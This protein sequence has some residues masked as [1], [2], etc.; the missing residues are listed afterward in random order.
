M[1]FVHLRT[2]TEYSVVDGTLRIDDAAD[3]AKADGQPALAI[4]D[5]SNLFGA[6][7]FY[8][9]CR[10]AGVKPVVGVDVWMDPLPDAAERQPTR[11]ALLV[12]DRG[13]YLN[14]CE[15]LARAWTQNVQR[16][17]A[18]L[19]WEWLRELSGGLIAMSGADMGAVGQALLAG[20]EE[21]AAAAARELADI[22]PGRFYLELQ[23][24][25][26]PTNEAQV[27]AAVPLAARL[28]LPVV[29]THPIQFLGPDDFEAHEARVCIAEGETLANPKRIKRFT[30]EQ[31]FKTAEQMQ[32]LFADVPSAIANTVEIARRCS[33]TLVLGKPRLPDFP[34]P[35]GSPIEVYF[36]K[37]SHEGLEKRLAA[38]FP[39]EE[40][41]DKRRPEYVE[42]LEFELDTIL[43]MGFPGYFLIVSDFIV[44]AKA[45]GC[46]VGP[47]RGSGAGSLVAY[48]LF[49]TDLDPLQYKL[50]F[51]RF[52]NPERVSM[53][54]FDIDFCQGNRD[55]VIRYVKEKY[56]RDAV[57]QIATFGTMAAKA[58]LR[59]VGRVLGMGYGHVDSIAKLIPAPPGKTVTL[60]KVPEKPDPG[61]IYARQEEPEIDRREAA[62]EEVAELLSLATRVEGMVRNIGMHAGGV[63]I[64]PGKITDF[65]PLYQ[66]PGSDSAVSQYDKDDVEAIGLV[67]FDF[68]GLATLTILEL[69]RQYIVARRPNMKDFSYET[70]PLDDQRVYKLFSDGLTEA[71]FQFESRGMQGML[72][73]AKPSRLEDLIALNALYR[74]GPMDLIPTFVARKHG[75]ETVEYPH[76][77]LETVLGETYG[78]MVYQEQVMQTAQV[79]GG[80]SLGG[81]DLLRR[82][83]GKKKAEE[84]AK[85]RAIFREGAA[86]KDIPEA[87]AD[88]VFDL[89]EKFAGYGFNKSHAAAYSLL[90][91]HTAWIK[92]HC[93]AEFFAA[94]MTIE[95]DN[96]DKLKVLLAD[97]KLF[98]IRFDPPDVNTGTLR[99]E[100]IE[101]KRIR[102]GLGAVKGTGAG[103][104]EAIVAAREGRSG[105]GGGPFRSLFDFCARVDRQRV[106]KRVVEALI[107]A[108][109]FDSLHADR[110]ATLASV[111]LAFE[112]A[113][114]QAANKDQGGLFDFGDAH[115][116][117]TQEPALVAVEPWS[118]RERLM[119]EKIAIGFYLSGHLFD[120]CRDEVRKFVRRD[121]VELVD[122][123]E[124]QSVAGIVSE[125]RVING[126]R[127]RVAIFKLD[128]GSEAIEAVANEELLD[129]SRELLREDELVIVVGKLQPDRF[130]GGLR[131]NAQQVWDLATARAR[132]G[133][134]LSV[135]VNGGLPPVADVLKLW[136]ARRVETEEGET[137][138]GLAVRL[139]LKRATAVGELD[140]GS[141]A[142][143]W[144]CDEALARWKTIAEQGRASI[145]YE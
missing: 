88:E 72:R 74:P 51:E 144:P 70:L 137:Q 3:A 79:L 53:P 123:R 9:A 124:P 64:A 81:A 34:T 40:E 35:D 32:A 106:N 46:P 73:E 139:K 91:Y 80:Y 11:L 95:A 84:M 31:H 37:A 21:R 110:A 104:I 2:H 13:G 118:V 134:Y 15:L 18:W 77:L 116:S 17:Q 47:G 83:M 7:K 141:D 38:L 131:L 89:M 109:A 133:R 100:P 119:Q 58:A 41:R 86:K 97:A 61:I 36:R 42:R 65:C 28:G 135:E 24:A 121:I 126:Q 105:D 111:G 5:L 55:R 93:T 63:L 94:N 115:G 44:W 69:A 22:F 25:G 66:Q 20:D 96:T 48:A 68:L 136:P 142:R 60:A 92:V 4:T 102:Y 127:G 76:P 52:L 85:H 101:D 6:I 138:Q 12:Q 78:V 30:R 108:G 8:K 75:K 49:I 114:T 129:A 130:S 99:F 23:R 98:G 59:D 67:K 90:A 112:W 120:A 29:A 143:F 145:V 140:L 14:L 122:S 33:L 113:D 16:N 128:D 87:K 107:K 57:G 1:P 10:G 39:K 43:K 50:L 62:E 26:L 45:N 132:F 54:D 117:S 56:G 27:R 71:V 82:A 125:L 103:A 19:K